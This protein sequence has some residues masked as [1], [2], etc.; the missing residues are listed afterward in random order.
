ARGPRGPRVRPAARRRGSGRG[1][2]AGRGAAGRGGAAFGSFSSGPFARAGGQ[3]PR[4]LPR[5]PARGLL[6]RALRS[7]GGAA[8]RWGVGGGFGSRSGGDRMARQRGGGYLGAA[9]GPVRRGAGALGGAG[10]RGAAGARRRLRVLERA[11]CSSGQGPCS[12]GPGRA[13]GRAGCE[14]PGRA[15]WGGG[16]QAAH[17]LGPGAGGGGG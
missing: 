10:A 2:D 16:R 11:P 9:G 1:S 15:R 8:G 7:A 12:R 6:G 14:L 13:A 4:G 17:G 3:A 5:S